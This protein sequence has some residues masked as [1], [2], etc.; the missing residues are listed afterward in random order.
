MPAPGAIPD[1]AFHPQ[2]AA[3]G[4]VDKMGVWDADETDRAETSC[5]LASK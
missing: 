5:A 4:R 1:A 3:G 2:I